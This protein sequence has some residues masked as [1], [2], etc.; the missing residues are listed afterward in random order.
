[1]GACEPEIHLPCVS[2]DHEAVTR[3]AME[4]LLETGH[5]RIALVSHAPFRGGDFIHRDVRKA[6]LTERGLAEVAED[7]ELVIAEVEDEHVIQRAIRRLLARPKPVTA[8][9]ALG[10]CHAIWTIEAV[11]GAGLRVPEDVAVVSLK[12]TALCRHHH[13]AIT[14]LDVGLYHAGHASGTL[15]SQILSGN[16]IE[17]REIIVPHHL[18]LRETTLVPEYAAVGVRNGST[19]E[20]V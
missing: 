15:L 16:P 3:E 7:T 20:P 10:D 17:S 18:I 13:P 12:D 11:K 9:L 1:M 14:A 4:V 5:E 2:E 19:R 8:F 6:V